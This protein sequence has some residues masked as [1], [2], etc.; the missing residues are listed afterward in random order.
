MKKP[1]DGFYSIV[2]MAKQLKISYPACRIICNTLDDTTYVR[3][4]QRTY[5]AMQSV[6]D[7]LAA[8]L[9]THKPHGYD[10]LQKMGKHLGLSKKQWVAYLRTLDQIP[11]SDGAYLFHGQIIPVYKITQ[12]ARLMSENGCDVIDNEND[13]DERWPVPE[14]PSTK[15]KNELRLIH[16]IFCALSKIRRPHESYFK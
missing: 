13:F 4:G 14:P 12:F 11:T 1:P 6:K 10:T 5:Y 9:P 7:S 16:R 3:I 8:K 2:Q 15:F